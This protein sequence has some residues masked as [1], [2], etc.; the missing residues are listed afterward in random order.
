MIV[1]LNGAFG[2]GKTTV[3]RALAKELR[4]AT[5]LDP[6]P[7]GVVLQRFTRVHDFQDLKTWRR[8]TVAAV[9]AKRLFYRIVIVPMAF[10]NV[11]Y[12][13]EIQDGFRR[14]DR[15]VVHLCL[16]AP[17]DVVNERL[18]RRRLQ[19]ADEAWQRR[20]AAE[21]CAVH[22]DP[23]FATQI[24]ATRSVADIVREIRST[25]KV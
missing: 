4:R 18:D 3:A 5:V 6:E 10:S 13:D 17:I 9:R 16:V 11:A 23:R 7:L 8:L 25:L 19:P 21:C 14:F 12:L 2:V 24:N 15:D 22:G 1:L 20:R